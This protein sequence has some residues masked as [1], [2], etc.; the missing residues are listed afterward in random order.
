VQ[1]SRRQ[2]GMRFPRGHPLETP[3]LVPRSSYSSDTSSLGLLS[4]GFRNDRLTYNDL[5]ERSHGTARAY[6]ARVPAPRWWAHPHTVWPLF[7]RRK[8]PATSP[9]LSILPSLQMPNVLGAK[10]QQQDAHR[11]ILSIRPAAI[12]AIQCRSYPISLSMLPS[13]VA[14][15]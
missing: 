6:T 14:R 13:Q 5:S 1:Y 8:W 10:D 3:D 11:C 7:R 2:Q 4:L 12:Y 15:P 9:P